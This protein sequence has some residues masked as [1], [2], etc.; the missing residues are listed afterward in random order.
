MG[1]IA[2]MLAGVL[3]ADSIRADS[4]PAPT[5]KSAIEKGLKR[6]ASGVVNYPKH[7]QCFSCH[8]Q[9]MAVLSMTA[10]QQH[11]FTVD[12]ALLN[13]QIDFSLRS[14]RHKSM[15]AKGRGVGGDSTS[16]VYALHTFAAVERPYDDT[17]AALV[18]YLL[19]RQRK[20]GAW[21]APAN[22]PPTMGSLFTNT[23]LA[24]FVLRKYTPPEDTP[25][26]EELRERIDSAF[27]RGRDWLLA[28]KPSSTEDKV[29]H[30]LGLVD[31][32][33]DARE[34]EAARAR[35][36]K[37][38]RTDGSWA[39]LP[40]MS[41]DAYATGTALVALRR[42][43]LDVSEQA[44]QKGV[45]YLLD[46]QKA[47]GAWIV[48]TRSRPIQIFF[49]NGDPGGKSQFISFAATNWAVLAL[50]E[51]VPAVTARRENAP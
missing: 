20:D 15:I 50:L 25:G 40:S 39:Q 33:V 46:S 26:A 6:I 17:M 29:F 36:L 34:I 43:G 19:V 1:T 48:K 37:D 22:R 16:V 9:A 38:Q 44:Y 23:G 30:L 2:A 10:A 5:V 14:F 21:P 47:D 13:K 11:G 3:L 49:D 42:A 8:H 32:G 31:A 24:L 35:L 28:N 12:A 27:T 51:T 45:K 7:R 4:V 41:G 18:E